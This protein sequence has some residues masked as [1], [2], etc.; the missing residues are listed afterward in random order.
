M[1]GLKTWKNKRSVGGLQ[2]GMMQN[3]F[4]PEQNHP[5]PTLSRFQRVEEKRLGECLDYKQPTNYIVKSTKYDD[6]YNVPVLTAGKV[7]FLGYTNEKDGIFSQDLPVVIFD[8]FT[9]TSQFV[10]F[11]Q[12]EVICN[13][14]F[15]K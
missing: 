6:S 8:D 10:N 3:F 9:T 2:K 14:N 13:E 1:H 11:I 5:R 12:G 4:P 7:L 15:K